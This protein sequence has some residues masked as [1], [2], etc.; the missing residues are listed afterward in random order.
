MGK[1]ETVAVGFV[2]VF[3]VGPVVVLEGYALAFFSS[4]HCGPISPG[5]TALWVYGMY[6]KKNNDL[7]KMDNALDR[8]FLLL[9]LPLRFG[10]H[11]E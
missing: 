5:Q 10:L 11:R 8:V 3:A 4:L 2:A 7:A 9:A 1:A 6:K